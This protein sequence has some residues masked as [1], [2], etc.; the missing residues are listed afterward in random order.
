MVL[1]G[2]MQLIIHKYFLGDS[3]APSMRLSYHSRWLKLD[4]LIATRSFNRLGA[5]CVW[6]SQVFLV[7][8]PG[9]CVVVCDC[10]FEWFDCCGTEKPALKDK[11]AEH[12]P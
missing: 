6:H 5:Y 8:Q 9:V 11:H 2:K 3:C 10:L 4:V 7:K 12:S 1:L